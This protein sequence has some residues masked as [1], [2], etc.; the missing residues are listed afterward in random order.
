MIRLTTIDNPEYQKVESWWGFKETKQVK[1]SH[2]DKPSYVVYYGS[3]RVSYE[4]W[5]RED[6]LHR[7]N[8]KPSVIRYYESGKESRRGWYL[9][10]REYLEQE[11]KQVMKQIAA[12]SDAEKLLDSRAWVREMVK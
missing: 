1:H 6:K 12:M 2:N 4:E 3:D 11:Y 5:R 9:D 8:N 7:S 10:G